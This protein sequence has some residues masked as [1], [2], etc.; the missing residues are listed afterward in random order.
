MP[1]LDDHTTDDL[2]KAGA[3]RHDFAYNPDAWTKMDAMLDADHKATLWLRF[4]Y[5]LLAITFISALVAFLLWPDLQQTGEESNGV[6]FADEQLY[7]EENI[8]SEQ[9]REKL[10]A[11]ISDETDDISLDK[12][13]NFNT[14]P[15]NNSRSVNA[16]AGPRIQS[17]EDHRSLTNATVNDQE[18]LNPLTQAGNSSHLNDAQPSLPN[19]GAIADDEQTTRLSIPIEL[20]TATDLIAV[21]FGRDRLLRS[22]AMNASGNLLA[23]EKN[24]EEVPDFEKTRKSGFALTASVGSILG[25]IGILNPAE[26]RPRF[27]LTTEYRLNNGKLAFGTGAYFNRVCYEADG[28]QYEAKEGF[29][30]DDVK[31]SSVEARCDVIEIPVFATYYPNGALNSGLFFGGGLTSY[32]MIKEDFKFEYNESRPNQKKEWQEKGTNNHLFGMGQINFGYQRAVARR[33]VLQVQG[34]V[35]V[36]LTG[37]GQGS[38]NLWTVGASVNY[39]FSFRR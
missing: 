35:Q 34:F 23:S 12:K 29:W 17:I 16:T 5:G 18:G 8:T 27:G 39:Q 4:G 32:L 6:E 38:V 20:L 31:A 33:S 1:E 36:P 24:L 28:E 3:E 26:I 11:V 19:Q 7:E 2:F 25:T 14:P 9:K 15:E 37:I 21:E 22:K 30:V 10:E 13:S